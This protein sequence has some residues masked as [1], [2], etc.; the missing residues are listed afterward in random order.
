VANSKKNP[1][2][3]VPFHSSRH[4]ESVNVF[5]H[6][7]DVSWK[8]YMYP[9]ENIQEWI[10]HQIEKNAT[11]FITKSNVDGVISVIKQAKQN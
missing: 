9:P 3:E 5:F 7:K 6:E 4:N 2:L 11:H 1:S 8:V 10:K